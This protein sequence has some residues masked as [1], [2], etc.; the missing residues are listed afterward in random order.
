MR[1]FFMSLRIGA[2]LASAGLLSGC[3]GTL[4]D[5]A[6]APIRAV[7]QAADWATTSEEEADRNRGREIREIEERFGEL[8]RRYTDQRKDCENGD[9]SDCDSARETWEEMEQLRRQIPAPPPGN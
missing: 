4:V 9:A 8:Q 6:T 1:P 5:L 7:G 3:V 2:A